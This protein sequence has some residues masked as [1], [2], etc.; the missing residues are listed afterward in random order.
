MDNS[1]ALSELRRLSLNVA[2]A[3]IAM[4]AFLEQ[5]TV[6]WS[7][8]QVLEFERISVAEAAALDEYRSFFERIRAGHPAPLEALPLRSGRQT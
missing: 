2:A 4:V 1:L 6:P 8:A 5:A 7:T 3:H